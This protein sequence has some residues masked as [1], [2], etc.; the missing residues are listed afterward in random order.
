MKYLLSFLALFPALVFAQD[1]SWYNY[2]NAN[3]NVF[4]IS[5]AEQLKGLAQLV[6]EG[7]NFSGKRIDLKGD[8]T[9]T[10]NWEPIGT[11][12]K[13]FVGTFNGNYYSISGLS[14]EDAEAAGLFGYGGGIISLTIN[15]SKIKGTKYAGVACGTCRSISDVAAFADSIVVISNDSAYAGGLVG[16][17]NASNVSY[18]YSCS[19]GSIYATGNVS[20]IGSNGSVYAGG[21]SGRGISIGS[22]YAT[23]N[24]SAIGSNGSVYAGGL[25]G[26]GGS[27]SNS[28]SAGNVSA[29]GNNIVNG[30]SNFD[31]DNVRAGGLSGYARGITN[32]YSAGNVSA[33]GN[34]NVYA[35]GLSGS[36]SGSSVGIT[37]SY[38]VGNIS[39]S[40]GN[41]RFSAVG[42]LVGN[43]N[44]SDATSSCSI[45]NSY[46]IG[47]V[48]AASDGVTNGYFETSAGG[49][50]GICSDSYNYS[51][52][53]SNSYATGNISSSNEA[54]AGGLVGSNFLNAIGCSITASYYNSAGANL[55]F[56]YDGVTSGIW[57]RSMSDLSRKETFDGWDFYLTWDILEGQTTPFLYASPKHI[58]ELTLAGIDYST[59]I[60]TPILK[61]GSKTLSSSDYQVY[62]FDYDNDNDYSSLKGVLI[63]GKGK[64]IGWRYVDFSN[65]SPIRLPQIAGNN[66]LTYTTSNAIVLQNLPTGAK[67]E[68]FGLSGKH[69]Y[70]A[71]PENPK[72]LEIGVQTKG[73]YIVKVTSRGVSNTPNVFRMVVK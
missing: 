59:I 49:L 37:N 48:S 58:S 68:V 6:N 63:V 13:P 52:S 69:I 62:R 7:I 36:L 39:G 18:N 28:Y 30:G 51:C 34:S 32:S 29:I 31:Y 55:D 33:I 60:P 15:A 47:D 16:D 26:Y 14:V 1:I 10:G 41:S 3:G 8:I 46:A 43:C 17:C 53:I 25:S 23:G 61:D 24:V 2:S 4:E 38:S 50:I 5:T 22:S 27:I 72:S 54:L 73:M 19:I 70:S 66:I 40:T 21:L 12:D 42:G 45:G 11:A 71:H 67:V 9:L 64:Y 57:A 56:G 44:A 35:G 20:A 65:S